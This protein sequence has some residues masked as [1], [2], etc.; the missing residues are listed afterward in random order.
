MRKCLDLLDTSELSDQS[1]D[2]ITK[3]WAALMVAASEKQIATKTHSLVFLKSKIDERGEC[4]LELSKAKMDDF[5]Q[6]TFDK[7]M[8]SCKEGVLCDFKNESDCEDKF[9]EIRKVLG[10]ED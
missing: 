1:V 10:Y 9:K 2:L 5:E 6:L 4:S 8:T 3:S 7:F